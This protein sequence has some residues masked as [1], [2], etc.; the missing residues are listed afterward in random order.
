MNTTQVCNHGI[1]VMKQ[2]LT[3]LV[4]SNF[5]GPKRPGEEEGTTETESTDLAD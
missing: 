4:I 5:P 1:D 2:K 3:D